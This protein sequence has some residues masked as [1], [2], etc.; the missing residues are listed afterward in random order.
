[1]SASKKSTATTWTDPDDAPPL[2]DAYFEQADEYQGERRVRRG[3]PPG[4][5]K[6]STTIRFDIEIL[7]AFRAMGP[8]WQSQIN[9]A[10]KDWLRIHAP[11][12]ESTLTSNR[13]RKRESGR[14]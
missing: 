13:S 2:T 1:M 10:L 6:V 7:E 8:G 4:S 3:R 5:R 12:Q 11:A 14:H 9:A